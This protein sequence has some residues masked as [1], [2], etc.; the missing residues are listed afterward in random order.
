MVLKTSV[1]LITSTDMIP[2]LASMTSTASLAS[3]IKSCLDFTYWVISLVSGTS[4]TRM[5]STASMASVA[6]M[7][8][9]AS[10]SQKTYWGWCFHQPWHQNGCSVWKESSKI[11][12]FLSFG[13]PSELRLWR[14]GMLFLIKSNGQKS[15]AITLIR[16]NDN[17]DLL[18]DTLPW[19]TLY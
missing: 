12:Y 10:F 6:S 11:H 7:T 9:T 13:H 14:T 5:T 1:A 4:A 8:S 16:T 2:S 3:K 18:Y 15:N 17:I 19:M